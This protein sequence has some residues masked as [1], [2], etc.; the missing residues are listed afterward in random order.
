MHRTRSLNPRLLCLDKKP[1]APLPFLAQPIQ[2]HRT[3]QFDLTLLLRN[4]TTKEESANDSSSEPKLCICSS[5]LLYPLCPWTSLT[6]AHKFTPPQRANN[7]SL[8]LLSGVPVRFIKFIQYLAVCPVCIHR[9]SLLSWY[10]ANTR[11][12]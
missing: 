9:S 8:L 6:H 3:E 2:L 1:T 12:L 7:T 4:S 11:P 10:W 5:F